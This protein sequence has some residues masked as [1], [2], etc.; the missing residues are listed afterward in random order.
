MSHTKKSKRQNF[1]I[2]TL[3]WKSKSKISEIKNHL[4]NQM[5]HKKTQ[6]DKILKSKG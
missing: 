6:S 1:E 2:K 5:S 3:F 4:R